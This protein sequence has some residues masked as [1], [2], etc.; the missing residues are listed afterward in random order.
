MSDVKNIHILMLEFGWQ[1][2]GGCLVMRGV[3]CIGIDFYTKLN[4]CQSWVSTDVVYIVY[5]VPW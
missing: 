1:A 2:I 3:Y 5:Y 4:L